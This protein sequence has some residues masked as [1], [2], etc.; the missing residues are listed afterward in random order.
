[1]KPFSIHPLMN[2]MNKL[3][4]ACQGHYIDFSKGLSKEFIENH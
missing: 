1:M 4:L 3:H 2:G